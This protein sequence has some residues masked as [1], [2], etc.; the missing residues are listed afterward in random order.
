LLDT[1][2]RELDAEIL[3]VTELHARIAREAYSAYGKGRG[4]KAQLNFGD[5]LA[6]ALARERNEP[7]LFVGDDFTHTDIRSALA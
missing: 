7:L 2:L 1:F 5:C 3:P 4:V 6:Y